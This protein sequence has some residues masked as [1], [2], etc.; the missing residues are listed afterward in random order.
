[1][2]MNDLTVRR[3]FAHAAAIAALLGLTFLLQAAFFLPRMICVMDGMMLLWNPRLDPNLFQENLYEGF[4][5]LFALLAGMLAMAGV[6]LLLPLAR[7]PA[8][9]MGAAAIIC[10]YGVLTILLSGRLPAFFFPIYLDLSAAIPGWLIGYYVAGGRETWESFGLAKI[11][12]VAAPAFAV[13]AAV[14]V[15]PWYMPFYTAAQS[16][17]FLGSTFHPVP[18]KQNSNANQIPTFHTVPTEALANSTTPPGLDENLLR[19]VKALADSGRAGDPAAVAATLHLSFFEKDHTVSNGPGWGGCPA[20]GSQAQQNYVAS[21]NSVP[22]ITTVSKLR[23][24]QPSQ[25]E[26]TTTTTIRGFPDSCITQSQIQAMFPNLGAGDSF[27]NMGF[28]VGDL[29]SDFAYA[30]AGAEINF[31]LEPAPFMFDYE[32]V[33]L[34]FPGDYKEKPHLLATHHPPVCL[35]AISL[36]SHSPL[37]QMN[38]HDFSYRPPTESWTGVI[39]PTVSYRTPPADPGAFLLRS[40]K[41]L[42]DSGRIDNPGIVADLL[43]VSLAPNNYANNVAVSCSV[44]PDFR[45]FVSIRYY[46]PDKNWFH[47]LPTGKQVLRGGFA[48]VSGSVVF[49]GIPMGDPVFNYSISGEIDC[50]KATKGPVA[51]ISFGNIPAFACIRESQ[52]EAIFPGAH[53]VPPGGGLPPGYGFEDAADLRYSTAIS[54]SDGNLLVDAMVDFGMMSSGPGGLQPHQPNCLAGIDIHG[55]Y[56]AGGVH[57]LDLGN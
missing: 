16:P 1:M 22:S 28:E 47:A 20:G 45:N 40:V 10:F 13:V 54:V 56:H 15:A 25:D 32:Y 42:A 44:T 31:W 52:I 27:L 4:G 14:V 6:R 33:D 57:K 39:T 35:V 19:T 53:P 18:V 38:Q 5:F 23:C 46:M 30:I 55:L 24:D 43:H 34:R 2:G 49:T 21:A 17:G 8:T 37:G 51:S 3:A 48:V 11:A 12:S 29:K 41:S 26:A 50:N 7:R 36:S 9:I